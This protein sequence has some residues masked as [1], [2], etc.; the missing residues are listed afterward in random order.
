MEFWE[1]CSSMFRA[2]VA[3]HVRAVSLQSNR[4]THRLLMQ[5]QDVKCFAVCDCQARARLPHVP[6]AMRQDVCVCVCA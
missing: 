3:V 2:V 6:H 5:H 1:V 4:D